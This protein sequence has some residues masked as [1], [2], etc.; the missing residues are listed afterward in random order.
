MKNKKYFLLHEADT[1]EIPSRLTDLN[2]ATEAQKKGK[3]YTEQEFV[4][5]F[6]NGQIKPKKQYLRI[7]EEPRANEKWVKTD[8]DNHQYGRRI[9]SL[10]Y[11]FKEWDRISYDEN[12]K[13]NGHSKAD[14]FNDP[15]YWITDK[16]SLADYTEEQIYNHIS[17]YYENVGEVREIYGEDANWIIAE[18]IF[19]QES[20]LY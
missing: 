20:G 7:M 5:A 2:F 16:V 15:E 3:V 17:A 13:L 14:L 12:F 4:E 8:P 18:C 6:A 19:E 1:E 11:E 10:T 9:D